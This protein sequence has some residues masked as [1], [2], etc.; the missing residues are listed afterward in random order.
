MNLTPIAV[1]GVGQ[2]GQ[3][4][5]RVIH[6][7]ATAR[8]AAVVDIQPARAAEV[9]A[10]YATRSFTDIQELKGYAQAAVL[11]VP[12]S[13]HEEVGSKL[14]EAGFDLLIEKPMLVT[15]F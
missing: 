7:S 8:L 12:T 14:L 4:H 10:Q 9:A 5:C 13:A 3:N 11:A 15:R 2:F 6:D 1:I